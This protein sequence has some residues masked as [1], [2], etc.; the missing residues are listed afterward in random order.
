MIKFPSSRIQVP[1][2]FQFFNRANLW[3]VGSNARKIPQIS[4]IFADE[5]VAEMKEERGSANRSSVEV[6]GMR[7]DSVPVSPELGALTSR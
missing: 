1:G 7:P 5:C 3:P 6:V 4:P 2:K